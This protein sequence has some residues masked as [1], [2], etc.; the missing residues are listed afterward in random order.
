MKRTNA[1][2]LFTSKEEALA[3]AGILPIDFGEEVKIS[4]VLKYWCVEHLYFNIK[5]AKKGKGEK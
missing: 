5:P 1:S 2:K 4:R 3:Y